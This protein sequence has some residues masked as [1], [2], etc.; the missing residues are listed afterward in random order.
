MVTTTNPPIAVVPP[1]VLPDRNG[2]SYTTARLRGRRYGILLFLAPEDSETAAYLQSFATRQEE[3][4]WLHTEIVVVMPASA[5][6]ETLPALPFPLLRDDGTVRTRVLPGL[7]P[8]AMALIV[9]DLSGQVTNW[10]TARRVA[11]LPDIE[12]ALGWAW[13]VAQPKGSCGGVTWSAAAHPELPPSPPAPI[14]RFT[15]G[16]RPHHGYRRRNTA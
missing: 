14:G 2:K 8:E 3:W 9:T 13:E 12:T 4:A 16:A 5:A 15:V 7:A 11:S 1:F 6:T 10:R